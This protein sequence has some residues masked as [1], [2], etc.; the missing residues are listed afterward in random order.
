MAHPWLSNIRN[1]VSGGLMSAAVAIPLAVGFGMFA[2]VALGD[3][4]FAD[5]A[6]AGLYTAFIVG[7]A[8][9]LLGDK[10]ATVYAPRITTTF[11]IGL[12]LYQLI[13]SE[14]AFLK[15]GGPTLVLVVFFSIILLGGALQSVFGLI[16]LGTLIKFTPH[17]VMAG[18]QN[19][20]ALLLFLVQLGNIFGF[21]KNTPYTAVFDQIGS[22]KP[23][24]I[25]IAAIT[26]AAMW[27]ARKILP[28]VPPLLVGLGLGIAI[29]YALAAL[30]FGGS[31]GP[32]IGSSTNAALNPSPIPNFAG[33]THDGSVVEI[34]PMIFAGAIALAFIASIDALLCAR[35]AAQPGD[36]KVDSDRL[37]IRLGLGN[38]A[39]AGFGGI[40]SGINIGPSLVNRAFGARTPL[41]V[42]VNCAAILL[43]FSV[44]FPL[45][46]AIPRVVLSAVIL[47]VAIQHV[48]PWTTQML[49]RVA[50]AAARQRRLIILELLVVLVVAVLS[51]TVN[52]VLAVFIGIAIAV[53]LFVVRMSRSNIRR[54]YRCDGVHSRKSRT[55]QE[56]EV[57]E[58]KGMAILAM[59]LEGAL[60][61]GSAE[62]LA[63]EIDAAMQ[64]DARFL[65]LDLRRVTE[66]DS[67]GA[68]IILG[69]NEALTR[70]SKHLLLALK[71][72]GDTAARL[73]DLGVLEGVTAAR[74]FDDVDR[75]IE[76]A[77]DM[78]LRDELS[79]RGVEQEIT[80]ED[81][82]ILRGF[83][84]RHI[85]A[86]KPYLTRVV[87]P[88]GS[89][90]FSEGDPGKE[91]F[92]IVS[93]TASAH[94]RQANGG[95]IRLVTFAPGTVFGELAILDAGVR[96]ASVTADGELVCY[97]L[98]EADFA[99]LSARTPAVAIKLLASLGRELS[100]RL[101]RANRTIHQLE[102]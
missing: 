36:A 76:W 37:L 46:A 2:F 39:A 49:R 34:I 86:I 53:L 75:A 61:F 28:K 20:A 66:I 24:S 100:G 92:F 40:T 71:Q 68:Q 58:H 101:R 97:V 15:S 35:L 43:A 65:I 54:T 72:Q 27:N 79:D 16:K 7:I 88:K 96:S 64:G 56:M 63:N 29:Y 80:L 57:L 38:M 48:D 12:L 17:P 74:V 90:I 45:I 59:E 5:G 93:G 60:F 73:G 10:T 95:D 89:V 85:A 31:L 13:H 11:F 70:K 25:A 32:V 21:D 81:V 26:C 62:R 84:P 67:T 91:L 9:V 87:H 82:G 78:L 102:V 51:I 69:I 14:A 50:S 99:A 18:F 30:G 1:D 42:L 47:V 22:A 94:L 98:S 83:E 3:E 8:N 55:A 4:Y 6:L 77:E 33:L 23:L 19:A 41:S 52:I 44:F